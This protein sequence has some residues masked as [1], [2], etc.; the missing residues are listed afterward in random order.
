MNALELTKEEKLIQYLNKIERYTIYSLNDMVDEMLYDPSVLKE[1]DVKEF[2][3]RKKIVRK[4]FERYVK[5]FL[6]DHDYEISLPFYDN[7]IYWFYLEIRNNAEKKYFRIVKSKKENFLKDS[8]I[9]LTKLAEYY[10]Y[11]TQKKFIYGIQWVNYDEVDV[12]KLKIESLP[13]DLESQACVLKIMCNI[14]DL[15]TNIE[16]DF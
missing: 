13:F 10:S 14:R 7:G 1:I 5:E 2:L 6:R 12:V 3:K 11:L 16:Y 4:L 8:M 9:V 15:G